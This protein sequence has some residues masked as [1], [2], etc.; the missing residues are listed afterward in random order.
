MLGATLPKAES[1]RDSQ[2]LTNPWDMTPVY[3]CAVPLGVFDEQELLQLQDVFDNVSSVII[4][5][6]TGLT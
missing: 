5:A 4:C 3:A 1:A 2:K 6:Y